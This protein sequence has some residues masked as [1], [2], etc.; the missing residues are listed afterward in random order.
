VEGPVLLAE[1]ENPAAVR[2]QLE[3]NAQGEIPLRVVD[4][5]GIATDAG[6]EGLWVWLGPDLVVV[7]ADLAALQ[8]QAAALGGDSEVGSFAGTP[9]CERLRARYAQ[10]VEIVVG[11]D[12]GRVLSSREVDAQERGVLADLGLLDLEHLIFEQR[13]SDNRSLAQAVLSFA[14]D[15]RGL[16]AWLAE[17]AS[18]GALDFVSP[19]AAMVSAFVVEDT[20]DLLQEMFAAVGA[21]DAEAAAGLEEFEQEH[22]IDLVEDFA[23]PLG[24]EVVVALDG[25]LAPEPSWK[26]VLE[27]YDPDRL[28]V[29]IERLAAELHRLAS[30]DGEG[31]VELRQEEAGGRT[32]HVLAMACEAKSVDVHYVF[33]DGYLVAAPNRV[34]VDRALRYRETGYNLAASSNFRDLLP[35][36]VDPDFSALFYNDLGDILSGVAAGLPALRDQLTETQQQTLDRLLEAHGP[37][38]AVA[39][40]QRDQILVA[41]SSGYSPL[42]LLGFGGLAN[43]GGLLQGLEVEAGDPQ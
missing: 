37:M 23:Q 9:F 16:A 17:P 20:A 4:D 19:E 36:G 5:P 13:V 35:E 41:G 10:G 26:L 40:A 27:V 38:V 1:V 11:V 31:S 32:Y 28:Q 22:G 33:A 6:E 34:L 21:R 15:R 30:E 39:H 25:P 18:I 12:L 2:E 29:G 7:A 24:G 8:K 42:G 3:G 14:A 43:M